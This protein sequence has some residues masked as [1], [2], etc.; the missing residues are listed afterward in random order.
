MIH[1]RNSLESRIP[2]GNW[3][4]YGGSIGGPIIKDKLFFFGDY[5]GTTQSTGVT[6]QTTIP[7]ASVISGCNVN[8]NPD[9]V[10]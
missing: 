5:Q 1:L 2:G 9:G 10:L 8:T 7:I 6:N 4:Q 3:K